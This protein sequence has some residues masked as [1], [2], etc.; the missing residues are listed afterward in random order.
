MSFHYTNIN[1]NKQ[2]KKLL[3]KQDQ[4]LKTFTLFFS[5]PNSNSHTFFFIRINYIPSSF[6]AYIP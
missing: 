4:V 6:L 5:L 3:K 1:W 2:Q